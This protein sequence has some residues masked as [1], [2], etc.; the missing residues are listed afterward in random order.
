MLFVIFAL[1][2]L[3]SCTTEEGHQKKINDLNQEI[4]ALQHQLTQERIKEMNLEMASQPLKFEEWH[5]YAKTLEKAENEEHQAHQ[6]EIKI[7]KL[8]KQRDDLQKKTPR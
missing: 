3:T 4:D 5:A 8:K 6:L 7:E 2:C 1:L